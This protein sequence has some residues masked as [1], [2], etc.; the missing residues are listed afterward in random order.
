MKK[1]IILCTIILILCAFMVSA[2]TYHIPL[3]TIGE[4]GDETFGGTADAY[5]E[6]KYGS[7]RIFLDSF[8]LTKLDTQIS[9]RYANEIAC[10][11]LNIDCSHYDF[12]YT[13]RADSTIVGGPS[14]SA[15][16]TVLTIAAL[17]NLELRNDTIM[18]GTINSGGSI[19]P[20]G[21]IVQKVMA[22]E[23]KG[24]KRV[25][26]PVF[27]FNLENAT[28]A[29]NETNAT[30][31]YNATDNTGSNNITNNITNA[32]NNT[33]QAS[34]KSSLAEANLSNLSIQI[35]RVNN[36]EE[37]LSYFTNTPIKQTDGEIIVP[38]AYISTM[39]K[40]S[41]ALCDRAITLNQKINLVDKGDVNKSKELL[42]NINKTVAAQDYYSA[43][44]YCFTLGVLVRKANLKG[45]EQNSPAQIRKLYDA[46]KLAVKYFDKKID[47]K[48]LTTLSELE[49]Y[50][51]VKERLM[52]A[53]QSLEDATA[54]M[55]ASVSGVS[56]DDLAYAV[57]RYYSGVYWS[58]FFNVKGREINLDEKY[59][60]DACNKK[61]S[62]AEERMDYAGLYVPLEMQDAKQTIDEAYAF[63]VQKNYKMC[64]F[65]A[66]F[67][68]AESNLLLSTIAITKSEA[69][70]LAQ[71][72]ISAT[73]KLIVKEQGRGFFPIM[74]YSY[75]EYSS[76]LKE[77]QDLLSAIIFSEYSLELSNM[78][79]Y[80]PKKSFSL[81]NLSLPTLPAIDYSLAL[82]IASA[83][84]LGLALGIIIG[85]RIRIRRKRNDIPKN[86]ARQKKRAQQKTKKRK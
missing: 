29:T 53:G 26:I 65:K 20:V 49:T 62:E 50:I 11:Y 41:E 32:T 31:S 35:I 57:E 75:Y 8:P 4:V 54:N 37:A 28:N 74:G 10:D 45:I 2:K 77:N 64:L 22:A 84:L 46:T 59:L 66:S 52:E 7:G 39:R 40:I 13:I 79:I 15:S 58:E 6:V 43:A 3:L 19:G 63:A 69:D 61:L 56:T 78:E 85:V 14:A 44:S 30:S 9:T 70:K 38:E 33:N 12:F 86:D 21:G 18:T 51:I 82:F 76:S 67:A 23:Q 80:F 34:G 71:E 17:K 24:Y 81:F 25:L 68:K 55:S 42:V 27:A 83:L 16:L 48:N 72:K 36:I 47:D 60:E 73:K 1:Q 5:L